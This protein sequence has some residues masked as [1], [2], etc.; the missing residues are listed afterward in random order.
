MQDV[1]R[2][3]EDHD[4][5]P[6]IAHL[7]NCFFGSCQAVRGKVTASN[8]QSRNQM[9]VCFS[10]YFCFSAKLLYTVLEVPY[11]LLLILTA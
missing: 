7:F 5:G 11:F 6:A 9:K 4:L 10:H 8:V 1:L 2:E 3:T